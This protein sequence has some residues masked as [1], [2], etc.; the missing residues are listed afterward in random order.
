MGSRIRN[1]M[2][3]RVLDLGAE[4]SQI[5]KLCIPEVDGVPVSGYT[6][7]SYRW[8]GGHFLKL[9]SQSLASF[10]SGLPTSEL[11]RAF[12]DAICITKDLGFRFIWIDALCILQDV[13]DD[14]H[15]ECA[16]MSSIYTN[17][18]CNIVAT[19]GKD[20]HT[21]LFQTRSF[22]SLQ[23]SKFK[24]TWESNDVAHDVWLGI[25]AIADKKYLSRE[26]YSCEIASRGWILQE[27][28]LS[29]RALYFGMNQVHW[30]CLDL[31]ACETWP[32]GNPCRISTDMDIFR[33][34]WF[35][36]F[37]VDLSFWWGL[38][39]ER[40]SAL[41]LSIAEDKLVAISGVAKLF[42]QRT[43]GEY[44]A[45]HWKS[46]LP[47]HLIWYR[48]PWKSTLPQHLIWYRGPWKRCHWKI[49]ETRSRS[50]IYTAPSW[51]WASV[52]GPVYFPIK[53]GREVIL[54][55]IPEVY[56][57]TAGGDPTGRAVDGQ[58][59]LRAPSTTAAV[60]QRNTLTISS[61][62]PETV[63]SEQSEVWVHWDDWVIAPL[64]PGSEVDLAVTV[65][66]F[67]RFARAGEEW[68]WQ[69][70]FYALILLPLE[71]NKGYYRR[72]GIFQVNSQ[73]KEGHWT[74]H[75]WLEAFGVN[76]TNEE[77]RGVSIVEESTIRSFNVV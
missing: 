37:D 10:R 11:P 14:F 59:T 48:G 67:N 19:F 5:W 56:V 57:N 39:V 72:V 71:S 9:T 33:S 51:S 46:T 18:S 61:L 17:S 1:W 63:N 21:S 27:L 23:I 28:L 41:N 45:G 15:R 68:Q 69:F 50:S 58:L 6:T 12:Q 64:P 20:P 54:C 73:F 30:V 42:Q 34:K 66:Y 8:G 55:S 47:Q 26:M 62:Y 40:Y 25:D 2:P 52:E 32:E 36:N 24:A 43:H 3:T 60:S 75:A 22:E 38:I 76:P 53:S 44:F 49:S 35:S 4:S 77:T 65:A 29:P 70:S 7:M 13:G 74:S 31:E 16:H